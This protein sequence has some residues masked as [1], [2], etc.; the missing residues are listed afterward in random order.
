MIVCLPAESS[1]RVSASSVLLSSGFAVVVVAA[2]AAAVA[3][4]ADLED[5]LV[6]VAAAPGV[7]VLFVISPSPP[8]ELLDIVDGE[9]IV[10]RRQNVSWKKSLGYFL[11]F[12]NYMSTFTGLV[13]LEF[14]SIQ[15]PHIHKGIKGSSG[16]TLNEK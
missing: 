2:A 8:P 12:L 5:L 7:D 1:F 14:K 13:S 11:V 16:L 4:A 6:V 15:R 3:A 10:S 9:D